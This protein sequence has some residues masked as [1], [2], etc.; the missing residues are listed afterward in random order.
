MLTFEKKK[1]VEICKL[2]IK[3]LATYA[4]FVHYLSQFWIKVLQEQE[5]DVTSISEWIAQMNDAFFRLD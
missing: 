5:Q 1:Y 4:Y 2:T 3:A